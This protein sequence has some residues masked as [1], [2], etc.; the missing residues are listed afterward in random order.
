MAL[1]LDN[2]EKIDK[3]IKVPIEETNSEIGIVLY[4]DGSVRPTNP[5][6][7]GWGVHGYTYKNIKIDKP[8]SVKSVEVEGEEDSL[9]N[10]KDSC[11]ITN[12][13]YLGSTKIDSSNTI[14]PVKPIIFIDGLGSHP[15]K[16]TNNYAELTALY[17]AL[18]YVKDKNFKHITIFSDSQYVVFGMNQRVSTYAKNG[19]VDRDGVPIINGDIW[20]NIYNL[21]NEILQTN[22]QISF[23]WVEAHVGV[24]GNELADS[25]AV[26][27]MNYSTYEEHTEVFKE[28]NYK[29]YYEK[30]RHP[31]LSFERIFFNS[32][33]KYNSPGYYFQSKS[34][35]SIDFVIGKR[36]PKAVYSI[37]KL[38]NPEKVI[39]SVKERQYDISNKLN[40]IVMIMLDKVYNKNIYRY[41]NNHGKYCLIKDKKS[42]GLNFTGKESITMEVNPTGLSIRA[43][44]NFNY[45]EDLLDKFLNLHHNED[46]KKSS[47]EQ[48]NW[49][50]ITD[51]FFSKEVKLKK[52]EE[53]LVYTLKKE[54][55]EVTDCLK[56]SIKEDHNGKE[57]NLN[58]PIILGLDILPRNNLKRLEEMEPNIYLITWRENEASL[59]YAT[60]IKCSDSVGIWSN[61]FADRIIL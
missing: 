61:F 58:I 45:L 40:M 2:K 18:I 13:G 30:D 27:G 17:K 46:N 10:K 48:L 55:D 9:V 56:I 32:V 22:C 37:I 34:N 29:D 36:L 1:I 60:I 7:G 47:S 20:K 54:I 53:V 41:L 16:I 25:S 14:Y 52:K 19:W 3:E 5:G 35:D 39:E 8:I 26:T 43:I 15:N 6:Y 42:F 24:Y 50:N 33:E 23:H 31:F 44:E 12:K 28:T 21:Y 51:N 49:F 57:R 38:N 4:T 11:I 59:R